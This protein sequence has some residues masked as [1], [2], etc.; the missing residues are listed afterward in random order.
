MVKEIEGGA[1][2]LSAKTPEAGGNFR[3]ERSNAGF[4]K[5]KRPEKG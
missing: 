1:V 5:I 2:K 3:L 4:E